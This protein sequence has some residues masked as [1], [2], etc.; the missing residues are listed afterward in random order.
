MV[1]SVVMGWKFSQGTLLGT[2]A[3]VSCSS[4]S[5]LSCCECCWQ[6]TN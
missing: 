3:I 1:R 5:H 6:H 4:W 2:E